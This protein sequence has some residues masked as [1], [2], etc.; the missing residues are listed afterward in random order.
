[1][2]SVF[3]IFCDVICYVE[4]LVL[5]V[6][7]MVKLYQLVEEFYIVFIYFNKIRMDIGVCLSMFDIQEEQYEDFKISFVKFKSIFEDL[8]YVEV[9]IEFN[10]NL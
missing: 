1:M 9:V 2:F 10:E 7:N 5:D 3:D 6:L 8:D 4:G